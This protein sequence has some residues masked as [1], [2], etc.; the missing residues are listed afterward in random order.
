MNDLY[1]KTVLSIIAAAL[2]ALV[3]QNAVHPSQAQYGPQKVQICDDRG[4]FCAK[5][6]TTN[7]VFGVDYGVVVVPPTIVV[8]PTK[9]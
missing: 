4:N 3:V 1:T 8:P 9:Q 6:H 2:L 7:T 5:V